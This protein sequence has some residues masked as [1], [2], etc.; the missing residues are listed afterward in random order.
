VL[1]PSTTCSYCLFWIRRNS[2]VF[3][4][5][6]T[7]KRICIL[8]LTVID[9]FNSLVI[10]TLIWTCLILT[11]TCPLGFYFG[12]N[13]VVSAPWMRCSYSSAIWLCDVVSDRM[14]V[15]KISLHVF[16]GIILDL[17]RANVATI[18]HSKLVAILRTKRCRIRCSFRLDHPN[19]RVSTTVAS[20]Y[21]L[22]SH[23]LNSL[24]REKLGTS[25]SWGVVRHSTIT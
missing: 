25:P 4:L 10:P 2:R 11:V 23:V 12:I 19:H 15:L 17:P 18:H 22:G 13:L 8:F 14:N 9:Y 5:R 21:S 20:A 16:V 7:E 1:T 24:P 3:T 6:L